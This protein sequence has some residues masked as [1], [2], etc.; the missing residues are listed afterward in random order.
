VRK[1]DTSS[2]I[3]SLRETEITESLS[4]FPGDKSITHRALLIAA[5]A[6]HPTILE[7]LNLGG[8]VVPL[9]DGLKQLGVQFSE[10]ENGL[11][12]KPP[13]V[14]SA[15]P[16]TVLHMGA[17][18]AAA[19]LLI[20]LLAGFGLRAVVDGDIGLRSRPMD[21]IVEPLTQMG[22]I[23]HYLEQPGCLPVEVKSS[24]FHGGRVRLRVT[25]AQ[26]LSAVLLAG[27]AANKQVV[28]D[29]MGQARDHTERL[30]ASLGVSIHQTYNQLMATPSGSPFQAAAALPERWIIPKDPS[31]AAYLAAAHCLSERQSTASFTGLCLNPTRL[32]FFSF[33]R[34]CGVPIQLEYSHNVVGEPVGTI[35]VKAPRSELLPV[36]WSGKA[37]AHAM[38]DEIPLAAAVAS[39]AA[40]P[41]VFDDCEELA[42]KETDRL[43]STYD[44]LRAFGVMI[45]ISNASIMIGGRTEKRVAAIQK[46]IPSFSDHRI[47][48]TATV[49]AC[50]MGN[51][52]TILNGSC[53]ETSYHDFPMAM[54][55]FGFP[56][57]A[58]GAH[59]EVG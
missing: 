25:S 50:V 14:L 27:F 36:H 28:I 19:R 8:A 52:M 59:I 45:D 38:I 12:V 32:G 17:S 29:T 11:E 30:L 6:G 37:R 56:V 4:C 3:G 10:T 39:F 33:L 40:G 46:M 16:G 54:R 48:M 49:L 2:C 22:A 1:T 57:N 53:C 34:M 21:W 7:G 55:S 58:H 24:Q 47:A 44:L 43:R 20:G 5:L 35:R 9:V 51:R 13:P 23:I 15:K 31:A 18:S 42:F 26:A 41:S